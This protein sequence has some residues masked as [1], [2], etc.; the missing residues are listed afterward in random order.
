MIQRIGE[1]VRDKVIDGISNLSDESALEGIKIVIDVK[2]EAN[3]N[4]VLNNLYKHTQ[5]QTS[6][7]INFYQHFFIVFNTQY[8][9]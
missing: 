5:L 8:S 1:L 7:G 4:V 9:Y 2:K 3:A 6:Y